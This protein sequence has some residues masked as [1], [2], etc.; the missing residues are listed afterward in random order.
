[1]DN[2][3]W[4]YK[5]KAKY[6]RELRRL[7]LF[8]LPPREDLT[9]I[10][11][12]GNFLPV[13]V[14]IRSSRKF[15]KLRG[16]YWTRYAVTHPIAVIRESDE[17][18]ELEDHMMMRLLYRLWTVNAKNV[19]VSD[20]LRNTTKKGKEVIYSYITILKYRDRNNILKFYLNKN[21]V[22][23]LVL[24]LP[25]LQ[26]LSFKEFVFMRYNRI[27]YNYVCEYKKTYDYLI[28]LLFA[29]SSAFQN[30]F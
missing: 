11:I 8:R 20:I 9:T 28:D 10:G 26:H 3:L 30:G 5:G 12:T 25:Q 15:S 17:L 4:A 2:A 19:S 1:M 22:N 14:V 16:W 23:K 7:L 29:P 24:E 6:T 27:I 13:K 21:R 18:Y